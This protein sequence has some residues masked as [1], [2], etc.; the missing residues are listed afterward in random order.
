MKMRNWCSVLMMFA[1]VFSL[2]GDAFGQRRGSSS[3]SR[4]FSSKPKSRSASPKRATKDTGKASKKKAWGSSSKKASKSKK[5]TS[6]DK[7]AY[8]KAKAQG[9]TFKSR[10]AAS[11]DFKKK[12]AAKYTSTYV[13]KPTTRPGHIPQT[14]MVGGTSTTIIYNQ[15]GGGYGYMNSLGTFMLYNAMADAAMRPY[16]NRQMASAGYYYG[17]PPVSG[18]GIFM[19]VLIIGGIAVLVI[20]GI[21]VSRES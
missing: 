11:A 4:S 16:Y 14:T 13:S 5:A 21:A 20:V 12:N 3:R 2:S 9:T 15:G 18:P 6:A 10:K 17:P 8:E 7:K 1:I 19:I